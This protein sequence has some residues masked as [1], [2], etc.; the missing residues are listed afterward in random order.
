MPKYF[1]SL[2]ALGLA[3]TAAQ[4]QAQ[5]PVGGTAR[6]DF[7]TNELIIPC[8]KVENFDGAADGLY[9]D[10]V[11]DRRGN[12]FNY[13]L[14]WAEPEDPALCELVSSVAIFEDDDL[15]PD[16]DDGEADAPRLL[17]RCELRPDRSRISVDAKNLEAGD[18]V[19]T[20]TSGGVTVESAGM[21][22]A[23]DEV[24]FDFDSDPDD[25]MEGATEIG[26]GFIQDNTV[27]AELL[28]D[29]AS[30]DALLTATVSCLEK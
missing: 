18:Y 27:T 6:A 9:Y 17:V 21:T 12:S 25:V 11:L 8:V 24:E 7:A 26:A 16:G 28:A 20:V 15:V 14:T 23:D 30:S 10:V 4:A 3:V 5:D 1:L 19:A 29:A 2:S 22:A 13:E